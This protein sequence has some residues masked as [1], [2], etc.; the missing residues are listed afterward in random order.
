M[1]PGGG[2]VFLWPLWDR[3]GWC[4]RTVMMLCLFRSPAHCHFLS[5]FGNALLWII[6]I[7]NDCYHLRSVND[8]AGTKALKYF[9]LHSISCEIAVGASFY[10]WLGKLVLKL[11]I[12][13]RSWAHLLKL[14]PLLST[15]LQSALGMLRPRACNPNRGRDRGAIFAQFLS[16]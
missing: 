14:T 16:I 15:H 1:L 2:Y 10:S 7:C 6:L 11:L 9:S 8:G 5:H 3:C 4:W 12:C 13:S